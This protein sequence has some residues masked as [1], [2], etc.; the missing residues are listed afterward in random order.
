MGAAP[1][2]VWA[3]SDRDW[4]AHAVDGRVYH[5]DVARC[6]HQLPNAKTLYSEPPTRIC[7]SCAYC[8]WGRWARSPVDHHAHLLLPKGEHPEGMLKAQCGTVMITGLTQYG[9]PPVGLHCPRCHLIFQ[10]QL[11]ENIGS[12]SSSGPES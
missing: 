5:P 11:S 12:P 1:R 6:G 2:W 3:V 8:L 10:E 9:Q 4:H 7:P